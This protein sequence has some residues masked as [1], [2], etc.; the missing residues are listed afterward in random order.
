LYLLYGIALTLPI[1][2]RAVAG[3]IA[4]LMLN[5][6]A[7]GS[8]IKAIPGIFKERKR[9]WMIS[10]SLLYI[11]YL[12]GLLWTTDFPYAWFDLQVKLSLLIFPLIFATTLYSLITEEMTGKLIRIFETGCI[13]ISLVFYIHAAYNALINHVPGAF[14]YANLSWYFHPAYLAMYVSFVISNMLSRFLLNNKSQGFQK[15]SLQIILMIHLTVFI[16]LLSSKAGLLSVILVILFY[17]VLL[18]WRHGQWKK[19]ATFLACSVIVFFAGLMIFPNASTRV[20]QAAEDMSTDGSEGNSAQSTSE[21]IIVWKAAVNIILKQPLLGVGTGDV[22]DEL[23]REY[24]A[25]KDY[26]AFN[27]KLNAHNQYLQT[28]VTL[29]ITGF[30]VLAGI[31]LS[32]LVISIKKQDYPYTAFILLIILNIAFESM[33]ETQ[34]G[35][36]FYAFFNI[37]LF[38]NMIGV[39]EIDGLHRK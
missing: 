35:V 36:V 4:L 2:S 25:K 5:W 22:K 14:F 11:V 6:I 18:A 32:S 30:I 23:L 7:E 13:I 19:A 29:G 39:K 8:W 38:C 17:T 15:K 10:F 27:Q 24:Y 12:A 28:M 3:L 37:L 16:I 33:F 20:S 21:R 31:I 26:P 34:A 1:H 9:L